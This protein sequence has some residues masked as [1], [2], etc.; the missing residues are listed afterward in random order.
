[1][2]IMRH[3]KVK[4]DKSPE[5][6]MRPHTPDALHSEATPDG[7]REAILR[8]M[9]YTSFPAAW[10]AMIVVSQVI[11]EYEKADNT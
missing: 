3:V 4:G 9:I 1:M 7:V 11:D 10:Q 2:P 5:G 6:Q 8:L